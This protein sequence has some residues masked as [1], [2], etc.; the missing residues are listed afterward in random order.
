MTFGIKVVFREDFEE[1]NRTV[2][3]PK[4]WSADECWTF[5]TEAGQPLEFETEIAAREFARSM[6]GDWPDVAVGIDA[7]DVYNEPPLAWRLVGMA[8]CSEATWRT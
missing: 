6:A 8:E 7:K 2:P 4:D 3:D 1:R 5:I